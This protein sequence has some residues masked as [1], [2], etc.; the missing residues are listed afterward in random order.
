MKISIYER[1]NKMDIHY[2]QINPEAK[3]PVFNEMKS[4]LEVFAAEDIFISPNE[5]K[6]V[7]TGLSFIFPD[8]IGIMF[9]P[10][11]AMT[12]KTSL[13]Y[14]KNVFVLENSYYHQ[15]EF[16]IHFKNIYLTK[17]S[18]KSVTEYKLIDGSIVTDD[19]NYYDEGT[20]K[21]RKGDLIAWVQPV[22]AAYNGVACPEEEPAKK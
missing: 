7:S 10:P 11:S 15:E 2:R 16:I 19:N 9:I 1:I 12:S 22:D 13:R 4:L 5:I 6:A 18:I 17:D 14:V 8:D 3:L 20:V 21:I